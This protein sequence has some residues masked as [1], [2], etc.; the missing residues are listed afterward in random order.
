MG[1]MTQTGK[2]ASSALPCV[3]L[4]YDAAAVS[5]MVLAE[6]ANGI[7][8]LVW[9]VD[10]SDAVMAPLVRLL[11]RLGDVVDWNGLDDAAIADALAA[12]VPTG[13]VTFG[14]AQ[15]PLTAALAARLSLT[16][17]SASTADRLADKYL[18]RLALRDAGLPGPAV[19]EAP[20][21]GQHGD[22]FARAAAALADQVTFPVVVKP[23][24]GTSSVATARADDSRE[25]THLVTRFGRHEGGLLVEEYL[26]DRASNGPFADDLAVELMAQN[27]RVWHL[28]TTGKFS[29]APPFRGRGCFLPSQVDAAT[30]AALF[31]LA[32]AALGALEITDGFANVDVKLT[33]DGPR[34]VEV[35]GR[36]GGNVDVLIE[37]AGGP[38]I[39]PLVFRLA[40]GEDMGADP[41][42][43]RAAVGHWSRI[44]YFAW[45]QTPMEATR[46][47]GV[48][49]IDVVAGLHHVNRVELNQRPGDALDWAVGGRSNVCVA[50]GSVEDLT[51]LVAAREEIDEAITL[52]F[53]EASSDIP[54]SV[55]R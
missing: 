3:A 21:P 10:G 31:E 17:H 48:E 30:E 51:D 25:L 1:N 47:M 36:L 39:L 13:I 4:V 5:P 6:A 54:S 29:H 24:R 27:G 12:H 33:P 45:V 38:S 23:R 49:G 26:T 18:Q 37:L 19:W 44:G 32:E 42:V 52:E 22:A 11:R 14:E 7:C 34:V 8:R 35:N 41:I 20:S 55:T 43:A 2:A 46:L 15:M 50:F 53:E 40:L 9:L 28:A 16:Y